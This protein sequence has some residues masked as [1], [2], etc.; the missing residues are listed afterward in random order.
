MATD[1]GRTR[2][3][4]ILDVNPERVSRRKWI[5]Q[6]PQIRIAVVVR[7]RFR[8][9]FNLGTRIKYEYKSS[10]RSHVLLLLLLL[11]WEVKNDIV[12]T[13]VTA[14]FFHI[15][16]TTLYLSHFHPPPLRTHDTQQRNNH[17]RSS[18]RTSGSSLLPTLTHWWYITYKR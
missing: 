10:Y 9:P 4:R 14:I 5:C 12:H 2:A 8:S 18:V 6:T 16:S 11:Q 13:R 17:S 15:L 3:I 1:C 7:L